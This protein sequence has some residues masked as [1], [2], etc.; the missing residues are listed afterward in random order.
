MQFQKGFVW[1]P[2]LLILLTIVV[3]G[4]GAYT[5][6][7]ARQIA[8][9]QTSVDHPATTTPTV[10]TAQTTTNT[11][12]QTTPATHGSSFSAS[13]VSG[14]SPL[15]VT[16]IYSFD[17]NAMGAGSDQ[18]VVDFGDGTQGAMNVGN[19]AQVTHT[20]TTAGTYTATISFENSVEGPF[21]YTP[22]KDSSGNRLTQ[23][24]T[25]TG[26]HQSGVSAPGMS[27]YTD[28]SFGFSFWYPSSK[29]VQKFPPQTNS[30]N[31]VDD[32]GVMYGLGTVILGSISAP[33]FGA[34]EVY[35]PSMSILSSV[36]PGPF[37]SN[38]DKYF[39]D[40]QS[41]TWMYT[42]DGGP[43]GGAGGTTPADVSKNTMGGLHIF[44]GYMRFG[45]K[46]IIP[47]SAQHFLVVYI[48]CDSE[49]ADTKA[50]QNCKD[51]FNT[52]VQTI[53]ATD[54]SVATP[55]SAAEQQAT[56]EAEKAAYAG[57]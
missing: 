35:S 31:T 50:N 40:M 9:T 34:S 54:P 16:F 1:L 37:G 53:T 2:V 7:N 6:Y 45:I 11:P 10:V 32:S 39:F 47:L 24:I 4:G 8:S 42:D 56:I 51:R 38:I 26:S 52:S 12:A 30:S 55:V 17:I 22:L 29:Q 46:E 36:D 5:Y 15:T 57:Q 44:Q 33:D 20:Y 43:K 21:S 18:F 14:S 3:V 41:H 49:T 13:A 23:T 28:S 48:V 27:Q 19:N 25:V